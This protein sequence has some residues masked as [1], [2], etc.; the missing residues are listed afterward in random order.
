MDRGKWVIAAACTDISKGE[1]VRDSY[2]STFHEEELEDRREKLL[3]NFWFK[4]LCKACRK[5]WPTRE[6]LP[7]NMF[8]VREC[9]LRVS[10]AETDA[11][12]AIMDQYLASIMRILRQE[13]VQGDGDVKSTIRLWRQFHT[14]LA[15]VVT[16]PYLGY[17]K[18]IQ[19]LRNSLW[20]AFGGKSLYF[21]EE[22]KMLLD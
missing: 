22:S 12:A 7:C 18:V 10:R 11:Y 14:T 19:G 2:G 8:E 4:C 16:K 3:K 13:M 5:R 9:Q 17:I 1:E 20:I 21:Y 6:D 15:A